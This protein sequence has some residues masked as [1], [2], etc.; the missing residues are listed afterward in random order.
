MEC[1]S[2]STVID[3]DMENDGG[4]SNLIREFNLYRYYLS[5]YPELFSSQNALSSNS[6]YSGDGDYTT[7]GG[8]ANI[9]P[10][11]CS[12]TVTDLDKQSSYLVNNL[13]TNTFDQNSK[14]VKSKLFKLT[15]HQSKTKLYKRSKTETVDSSSNNSNRCCL[16][17]HCS[18]RNQSDSSLWSMS[19][20]DLS[21]MAKDYY[22]NKPAIFSDNLNSLKVNGYDER[23][24]HLSRVITPPNA[25]LNHTS[26]NNVEN[27][28]Q[29]QDYLDPDSNRKSVFY[30][31]KLTQT[32][33]DLNVVHQNKAASDKLQRICLSRNGS[34]SATSMS[35]HQQSATG[36]VNSDSIA[37]EHI[38]HTIFD[39]SIQQI[40]QLSQN[41]FK[42]KTKMQT[43]NMNNNDI[44]TNSN[45]INKLLSKVQS[46]KLDE[47]K[48]IER[49]SNG[50]SLQSPKKV[51]DPHLNSISQGKTSVKDITNATAALD[52]ASSTIASLESVHRP[53]N[54]GIPC[55]CDRCRESW[56]MCKDTSIFTISID[57]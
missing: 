23:Y 46:L 54:D 24:S 50:C 3:P 19:E 53:I 21:L 38:Y 6:T 27:F 28:N 20:P 16:L 17:C 7:N 1:P 40:C 31:N 22:Y 42:Q 26:S 32:D 8:A 14:T 12:Q 51:H 34:Y 29:I 55:S 45:S 49:L 11:S 56:G 15:S 41:A 35:Q 39:Q 30:S 47:I 2:R 33:M 13:S 52:L 43:L 44:I 5:Q 48:Q 25:F 57:N 4:R 18:N 10:Q 37:S 9:V 36:S